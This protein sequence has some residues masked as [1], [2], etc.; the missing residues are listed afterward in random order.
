LKNILFFLPLITVKKETI[1]GSITFDTLKYAQRMKTVG[2]TDEQAN[3][4]AKAIAEIIDEK[5]ATKYDIELL[6]KDM[7]E[8]ELRLTVRLGG[9][10]CTAI[11]IVATLVKL[12]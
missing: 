10:I 4:Q 12:L 11:V 8:L 6:R 5:L 2:F 7:K 1:M 3:E 9:M